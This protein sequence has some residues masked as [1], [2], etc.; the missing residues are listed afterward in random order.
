MRSKLGLLAAALLLA[1][2]SLAAACGDDGDEQAPLKIGLLLNFGEGAAAASMVRQQSFEL[3]IQ[4]INDAGGVLGQPVTFVLAD[5]SFD[6]TNAVEEARRLIE[7]EGVHAIVGPSSSANA[8]AVAKQVAGP[9]GIPLISPSATSPLLTTADDRDFFFRTALSDVAQAPVL[10]RLTRE[11]GFDNVGVV[12]RD[13]AWGRGLHEAFAAAWDGTIASAAIDSAAETHLPALRETAAGGAQ[14]LVVITFAAEAEEIL[15]EAFESSLYDQF[16]FSDGARRLALVQTFGGERLGDMYGTAGVAR[17]G[18][19]AQAA[20]DRAYR[21][22][23]GELPVTPY[24]RATYD[25]A[26]AIALAA[27]AAG[28]L[29]GAAIRDKLRAIGAAP[30]KGVIAGREGV[31]R[32]IEILRDGGEVDY[33]GASVSLDWDEHGDLLRGHIGI[34][35]FTSDERI[36]DLEAEPYGE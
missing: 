4:H 20:W 35:R 5:P 33:D 15:R 32:A 12:Y 30:G 34:W 7:V 11:R 25:A 9:A 36:E 14:A 28:S 21:E 17:P 2:L 16:V 22:A 31:A 1:G 8:L 23:Y 29:E 13:D 6:P 24:V 10:A 18:G 3:A 26:V 27:E 19:D